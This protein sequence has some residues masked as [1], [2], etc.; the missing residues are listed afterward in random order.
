MRA[1][2]TK[3]YRE[4]CGL[5]GLRA[6]WVKPTHRMIIIV[7]RQNTLIIKQVFYMT[8]NS[9]YTA[10]SVMSSGMDVPDSAPIFRTLL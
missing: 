9:R 4:L 5:S 2:M 6:N 10:S 3:L 7:M 8:P 1:R